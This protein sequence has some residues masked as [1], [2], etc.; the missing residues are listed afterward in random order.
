MS[1]MAGMVGRAGLGLDQRVC[2]R[3]L[4]LKRPA[5]HAGAAYALL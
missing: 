1:G 3:S 5:G 4:S 2:Q